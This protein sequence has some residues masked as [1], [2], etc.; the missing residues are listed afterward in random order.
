MTKTNVHA[1]NILCF[2]KMWLRARR[3]WRS[4]AAPVPCVHLLVSQGDHLLHGRDPGTG[5]AFVVL[6]HFDGLQPLGHRPEHGAVTA[7]GAGQA[8]GYTVRSNMHFSLGPF[9][10]V[11]TRDNRFYCKHPA[12]LFTKTTFNRFDVIHIF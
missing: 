3:A 9:Y 8:D 7:T 1:L 10:G 4:R 6:T 2:I 11:R 5:E 12:D